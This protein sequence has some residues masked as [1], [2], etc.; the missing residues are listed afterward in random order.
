MHFLQQK[1]RRIEMKKILLIM[2][3]GLT[4]WGGMKVCFS[5]GDVKD[6]GEHVV[7]PLKN[8]GHELEGVFLG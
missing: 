8:T 5:N 7:E 6:S 1:K 3:L 2:V 4:I